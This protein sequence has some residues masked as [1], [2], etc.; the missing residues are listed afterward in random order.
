MAVDNNALQGLGVVWVVRVLT[1]QLELE[2]PAARNLHALEAQLETFNI[3]RQLFLGK[4]GVIV[5]HVGQQ[6]RSALHHISGLSVH[7]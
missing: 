2:L 5:R 1:G 3:F 6:E 4:A 7:V